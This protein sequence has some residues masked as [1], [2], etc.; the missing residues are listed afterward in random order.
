MTLGKRK[1]ILSR[2]EDVAKLHGGPPVTSLDP[3]AL[4]AG[5]PSL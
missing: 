1:F 4:Q 5:C 3:E 2:P